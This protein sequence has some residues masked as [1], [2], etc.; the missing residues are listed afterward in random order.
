MYSDKGSLH[1]ISLSTKLTLLLSERE[2]HIESM[3][4]SKDDS[5]LIY[6]NDSKIRLVWLRNPDLHIKTMSVGQ[7][8]KVKLIN[9][10]VFLIK[11]SGEIQRFEA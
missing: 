9:G 5:L 6:N 11:E 7:R 8:A 2:S 4:L 1:L 3:C 10:M